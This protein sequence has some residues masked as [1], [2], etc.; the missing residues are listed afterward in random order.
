MGDEGWLYEQHKIHHFGKVLELEEIFTLEVREEIDT[1]IEEE[2]E[3]QE[4]E[5]AEE[6][7]GVGVRPSSSSS[8]SRCTFAKMI[9][10]KEDFYLP[11]L[12][13]ERERLQKAFLKL[14]DYNDNDHY[15]SSV[16]RTVRE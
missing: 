10:V 16:D 11:I 7:A 12:M 2:E 8:S 1:E 6:R 15:S 14:E 9:Y 4:E 13:E 5:E 3:Q